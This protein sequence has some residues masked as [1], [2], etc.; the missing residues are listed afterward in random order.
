MSSFSGTIS[1]S[2]FPVTSV[3]LC[4]TTT[5]ASKSILLYTFRSQSPTTSQYVAFY[6]YTRGF[7]YRNVSDDAQ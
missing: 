2:S 3:S 7:I 4:L 6:R 1:K 5:V